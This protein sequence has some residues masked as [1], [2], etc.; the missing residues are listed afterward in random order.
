MS[1]SQTTSLGTGT[2]VNLALGPRF[3]TG[4]FLSDVYCAVHLR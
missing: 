4:A 3:L 2:D 1:K